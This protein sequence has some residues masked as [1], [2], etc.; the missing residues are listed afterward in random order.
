[1]IEKNG[2]TYFRQ[3]GQERPPWRQH[4][5]QEG[6]REM[7]SQGKSI[8]GRGSGKDQVLKL[9]KELGIWHVLGIIQRLV[10]KDGK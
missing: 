7:K 6:I 4:F 8:S 10:G 3:G 1:M 5:S 2:G 9:S